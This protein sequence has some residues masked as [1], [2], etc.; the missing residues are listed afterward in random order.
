MWALRKARS[1]YRLKGLLLDI[2]WL[3]YFLHDF[4]NKWAEIGKES[5]SSSRSEI[6]NSEQQIDKN[7]REDDPCLLVAGQRWHR[8]QRH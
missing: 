2:L 6:K 3:D 1:K 5:R 7:Y 8:M 4:T